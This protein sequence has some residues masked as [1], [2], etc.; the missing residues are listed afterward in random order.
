ML[1]G[2]RPTDPVTYVA[3]VALFLVLAFVSC[4]LPARR[5]ASLDPTNALRSD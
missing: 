4:L 1:I 2:V 3:I 5:A